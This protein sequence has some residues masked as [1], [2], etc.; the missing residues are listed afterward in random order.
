M[1]SD[2]VEDVL[3]KAH[4]EGIYDD[5]IKVSKTLKGSYWTYGEKIEEAYNI[6]IKKK[7]NEKNNSKK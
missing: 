7:Q 4:G 6:V 3:Y 5:V 1:G 2:R